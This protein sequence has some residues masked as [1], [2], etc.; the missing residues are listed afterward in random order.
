MGHYKHFEM[1]D[2][3]SDKVDVWMREQRIKKPDPAS[4]I[5]GRFSFTFIPTAVG[6]VVKVHDV[7]LDEEF[8]ATEYVGW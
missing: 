6:T 4:S 7:V 3:E 2:V 8:D 1:T 5:G